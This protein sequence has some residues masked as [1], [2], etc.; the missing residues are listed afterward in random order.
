VT[1]VLKGEMEDYVFKV[2][3]SLPRIPEG[4]FREAINY[5]YQ[6]AA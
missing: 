4:A 1:E 6:S 2:T 3:K 5:Y